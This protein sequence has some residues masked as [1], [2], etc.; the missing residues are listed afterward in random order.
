MDSGLGGI[1]GFWSGLLIGVFV[2]S[3]MGVLTMALCVASGNYDDLE[4]R[5][6]E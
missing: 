5:K 2:G 3:L 6:N 4:E 1:V